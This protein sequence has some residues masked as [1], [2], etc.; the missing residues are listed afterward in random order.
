MNEINEEMKRKEGKV[1]RSKHEIKSI[2]NKKVFVFV[3]F[4]S[5]GGGIGLCFFNYEN[6]S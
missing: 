3:Y 2:T 4:V 6:T 1:E 5:V